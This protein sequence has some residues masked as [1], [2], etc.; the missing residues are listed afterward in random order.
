MWARRV[1]IAHRR[2]SK[3]IRVKISA[4]GA[5]FS[6][7]TPFGAAAA[8]HASP[9]AQHIPQLYSI[10]RLAEAYPMPGADRARRFRVAG[11]EA[12][13]CHAGLDLLEIRADLRGPALTGLRALLD[14][15]RSVAAVHPH[16]AAPR[17]EFALTTVVHL[18]ALG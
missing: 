15:T 3:A 9:R 18:E 5:R 1:S 8:S 16:K 12:A 6:T 13:E 7:S 14:R 10:V 17:P 11:G 2:S 4:L